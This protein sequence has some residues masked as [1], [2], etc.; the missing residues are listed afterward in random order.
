VKTGIQKIEED[1]GFL[2][3]STPMKIGAGMTDRRT[4]MG[5]VDF[6]STAC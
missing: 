6:K 5:K 2:L 1:T 4:K 3:Q